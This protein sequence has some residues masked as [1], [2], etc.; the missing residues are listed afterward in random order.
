MWKVIQDGYWLV[1]IIKF[2]CFNR[3]FGIW[4]TFNYFDISISIYLWHCLPTLIVGTASLT[5]VD[6]TKQSGPVGCSGIYL[7]K[8]R[9]VA[10]FTKIENL[11]AYLYI[12]IALVMC[13]SYCCYIVCYYACSQQ[14]III[15]QI[16]LY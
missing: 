5:L 2:V 16:G 7:S 9:P 15:F 4:L 6:G 1:I 8:L 14:A 13:L 12:Y 10:I 3:V 11:C